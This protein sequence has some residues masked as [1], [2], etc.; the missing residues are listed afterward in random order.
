M[1]AAPQTG[2]GSDGDDTT[3]LSNLPFEGMD[4]TQ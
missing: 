2:A 3:M 4:Y 1:G